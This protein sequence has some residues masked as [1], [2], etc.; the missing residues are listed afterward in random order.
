MQE[1]VL[2]YNEMIKI[3]SSIIRVLNIVIIVVWSILGLLTACCPSISTDFLS[4]VSTLTIFI[5]C[6]ETIFKY[7]PRLKWKIVFLP[8]GLAA[9]FFLFYFLSTL[10]Q[11]ENARLIIGN[12]STTVGFTAIFINYVLEEK[13]KD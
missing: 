13:N 11:T 9:Y 10:A 7:F 6:A 2:I 3:I 5:S 4:G 1:K 12:C 8:L